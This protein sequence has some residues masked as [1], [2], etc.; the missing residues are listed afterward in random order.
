M[1]IHKV[2]GKNRPEA[3]RIWIQLQKG[4]GSDLRQAHVILV[5]H[6]F[7]ILNVSLFLTLT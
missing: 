5:P 4:L 7:W 6:L 3:I 2:T 1:K